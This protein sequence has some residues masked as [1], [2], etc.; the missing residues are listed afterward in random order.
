MTCNSV[1]L[2]N[3]DFPEDD[4]MKIK[5]FRVVMQIMMCK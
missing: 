4:L 3:I 2:Y 1:V 5:T